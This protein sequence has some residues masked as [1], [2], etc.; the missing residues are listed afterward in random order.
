M[1]LVDGLNHL[2]LTYSKNQLVNLQTILDE[3]LKWN[4]VFNLSAHRDKK[5]VLIYQI[6]DSLTPHDF[7]REG[8]LL[9]IGSGPGFPGLP[10][11]LF[12]PDTHV[13]I[14][15]SN[16]KKLTF[17]RHIRALCKVGN[18]TI[19]HKRIEELSTIHQFDQ[20]I[21]RAFTHLSGIIDYSAAL[22]KPEGEILAMKGAKAVNEIIDAQ[23]NHGN[24][25]IW[26]YKLP[27]IIDEQRMLVVVKQRLE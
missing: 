26:L 19:V 22:L 23:S 20:I 24:F 9:D 27:H 15:D 10:L 7:I 25:M 8:K 2:G 16:D 12:F 18:L 11:A 17:A 6:L 21:S 5:S 13:T 14:V 1:G 3:H 4:K